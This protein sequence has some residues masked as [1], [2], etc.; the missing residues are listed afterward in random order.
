M[1]DIDCNRGLIM[2][3]TD[4]TSLIGEVCRGSQAFG[5]LFIAQQPVTGLCLEL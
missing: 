5:I 2:S 3:D 4:L 1:S